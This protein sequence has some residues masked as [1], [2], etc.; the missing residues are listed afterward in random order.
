MVV[1]S[2]VRR[3]RNTNTPGRS[4]L[5]N[6]QKKLRVN[7]QVGLV[8]K[9]GRTPFCGGTLISSTHVLTAAH[10]TVG[11]DSVTVSLFVYFHTS[12]LTIVLL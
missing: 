9:N 2:V 11:L 1:L 12:D 8:R 7:P 3:P 4:V 6:E 5:N 10:C